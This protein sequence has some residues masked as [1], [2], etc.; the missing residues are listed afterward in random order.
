MEPRCPSY[1]LLGKG[2]SSHR[3]PSSN[4]LTDRSGERLEKDNQG[5]LL[6]GRQMERMNLGINVWIRPP[7]VVV[8]VNDGFER[9]EAAVVHVGRG[10]L[11]FAQRRRLE[12]A[13]IFAL[14]ASGEPPFVLQP[15]I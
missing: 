6:F 15:A 8:E 2:I 7:A 11:H 9:R 10:A 4:T 3:L 14:A 1:S 13:A 5:L 12:R